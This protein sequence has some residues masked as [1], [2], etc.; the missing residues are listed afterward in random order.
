M[1]EQ[2]AVDANP[3]LAAL[4]GG[5]ASEVLFSAQF[6]L[7]SPQPVLFEV[8]KYLPEVAKK[9]GVKELHLYRAFQLLPVEACQPSTYSGKEQLA[10]RLIAERD[11]RD[12]PLLALALQR[13]TPI[14]SN[15]RDFQ[16]IEGVQVWSTGELLN[17]ISQT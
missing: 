6:R 5:K 4:L 16:G 15:D 9:I 1:T 11:P 10:R 8:A 3:L 14:W 7:C 13:N 17:R 2:I 12:V